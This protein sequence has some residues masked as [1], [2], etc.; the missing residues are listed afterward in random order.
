MQAYPQEEDLQL[1][2]EDE[3]DCQ[4]NNI[5]QGQ[6]YNVTVQ[7]LI[8]WAEQEGKLREL[9]IGASKSNPGNPKLRNCVQELLP[10]LLD[11]I[12]R[13]LLSH[14]LFISLIDSLKCFQ[15]FA[16]VKD[17]CNLTI[18][19]LAVH[20][21]QQVLDIGNE[22]LETA[23]RWLI[24]LGLLLKDYRQKADGI[25]YIVEF[26]TCLQSQAKL[27]Q[28]AH[29]A[30]AN[31]FEQVERCY[32]S[33]RL[34]HPKE[35]LKKKVSKLQGH[36]LL[37]VRIPITP[38][39]VEVQNTTFWVNRLICIETVHEDGL[40]HSQLVP[41]QEADLSVDNAQAS[42]RGVSCTLKQI[43]ESLLQWV[44]E[45]ETKLG[46]EAEKLDCPYDLTV[47]F[48]LP[49]EYLAEAV[50]RW[51]VQFGPVRLKKLE[52]IGKKHQVV[53]RSLD[54]LED[55][56]LFNR[57]VKTWQK[58]E[59][60]LQS[61]PSEKE[62]KAEIE[63]LDCLV[64]CNW[65][66]LE[67]RLALSQRIALKLTCAMPTC[68]TRG[69]TTDALGQLFLSILEGGTPIALWSRQC[70]LSSSNVVSQM[71]E[72][73]LTLEMLCN[74]DKLLEQVKLARIAASNDQHPGAHLAILCDEPQRLRQLKQFLKENQLWGMSA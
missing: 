63:Q 32:G 50:D 53:V 46:N 5:S 42:Q 2:L 28:I 37:V 72:Q 56:D 66:E 4:L 6:R 25:P 16:V 51:K 19:D 54:R 47:E 24:V 61:N 74:S 68:T 23:V 13:N 58:A 38:A 33:P 71:M 12:D 44:R 1:M 29:Q 20:R 40:T 59:Q 39:P 3:L 55:S 62:I 7:N 65:D 67:R 26:V 70:N 18:P 31:W 8:K 41:P 35:T 52:S 48:F 30:L 60:L 17:C 22:D 43:E 36:L 10:V 34:S 57:L 11:D 27:K 49:Y 9:V 73:L 14:E 64:T 45:A 69:S 15:D 21:P